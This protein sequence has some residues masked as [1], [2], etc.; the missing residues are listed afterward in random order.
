MKILYS[1]TL[2]ALPFTVGA[3]INVTGTVNDKANE[4]LGQAIDGVWNGAG[5][6]KDKKK[7]G[8]DEPQGQGTNSGSSSENSSASS[9]QQGNT[10]P[11]IKTYQN[12]DFVAGT[13]LVFADDFI[14]DQ[15]GEFPAHWELES[16]Q[17]VTNK[18]S[19]KPSFFLTDGNY[20][21]VKPR[22]TSAKYLSGDA[23][24]IEADI[25][26]AGGDFGLIFFFN[27]PT[28]NFGDREAMNIS[29]N[30]SEVN[31]A[32]PH[33]SPEDDG[34][35]SLGA[36][37]PES[38]KSDYPDRWHHVAIAYKNQQ[39]KVY[40]DQYRVLVIPDCHCKPEHLYLGGIG[41]E[42]NPIK[43]T[44]VRIANGGN[45]NMINQLNTAGKIVSYGITFDVNK[46]DIK[47]ESM[48]TLNE[49]A[50][51]M[52]DNPALKLEIGG[53]CDSD[54]DDAS[55]LKLSQARADAVRNQLI[56]M[57]VEG[58]RL[59]A[60]GYGETKPVAPNS[61]FEGKAKNRRVEFVKQ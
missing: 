12:Y 33:T 52:K 61:T 27:Q 54:G 11:S 20:V 50:K 41:S 42:N 14:N 13:E 45:Q 22:M 40:V 32:F 9:S 49:I 4:K 55:N 53:H 39:V 16:G 56:S 35:A 25:Y 58:S 43:F 21:K 2:L 18:V 17:A 7:D 46:A 5:K 51:M 31:A 30:A 8:K 3:Q 34:S 44:N 1:L 19:G 6:T 60:K 15:D 47:P 23:W 26:M 24:T 38:L 48:G 28:N 57:G 59:T 36:N 37:F 29:M 10:A